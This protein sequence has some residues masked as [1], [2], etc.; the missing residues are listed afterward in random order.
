MLTKAVDISRRKFLLNSVLLGGTPGLNPAILACARTDT[1]KSEQSDAL[2]K[3]T[4]AMLS[5][6]RASWEHGVAAQ[7]MLESGN[8]EVG[9]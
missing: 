6:Q 4:R 8:D 9:I 3:V 5:M 2:D 1:N 7:A